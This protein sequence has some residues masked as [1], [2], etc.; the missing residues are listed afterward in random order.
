MEQ[1]TKK[2]HNG[3]ILGNANYSV[4]KGYE[5]GYWNILTLLYRHVYAHIYIYIAMRKPE[6]YLRANLLH[7]KCSVGSPD[8]F[9][10]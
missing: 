3:S 6:V 8:Q 5:Y 7:V 10:H 4:R 2:L 1:R 9:S